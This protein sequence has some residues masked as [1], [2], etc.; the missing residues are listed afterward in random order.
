[1]AVTFTGRSGAGARRRALVMGRVG[2]SSHRRNRE[3]A[4]LVELVLGK[5]RYRA[6][7]EVL[8]GALV[9][10]VAGATA[11]DSRFVPQYWLS[12]AGRM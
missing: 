5:H 6:V 9:V 2:C 3:A 10:E 7:M 11:S 1:M 8:D 12:S 4:V